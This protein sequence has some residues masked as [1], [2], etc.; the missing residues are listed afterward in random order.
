MIFIVNYQIV[1]VNF[2][3]KQIFVKLNNVQNLQIVLV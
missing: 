2:V 3:K 1:V